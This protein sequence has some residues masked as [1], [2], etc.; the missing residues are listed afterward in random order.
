MEIWHGEVV[1]GGG[2]GV[3]GITAL[4]ALAKVGKHDRRQ[5]NEHDERRTGTEEAECTGSG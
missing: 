5:R 4:S 3:G 2:E 1:C